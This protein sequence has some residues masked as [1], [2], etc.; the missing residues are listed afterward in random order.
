MKHFDR[1]LQLLRVQ[2]VRPYIKPGARVLDIGCADGALYRSVARLDH[3]VGI[4]PD[5]PTCSTSANVRF[6]RG[7][8]PTA[9][10]DPHEQFD[11]IA[12]LAVLEHVPRDAHTEFARACAQHMAPGGYLAITVPSPIVDPI[13]S[14]LKSVGLLDGMREDQHY[15]YDP[16]TTPSIFERHGLRLDRH[17]RFELGLNHLFVFQQGRG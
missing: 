13:I 15:G 2:R 12:A 7:T 4:D 17:A 8:F 5:A 6:I 14:A 11:V 9:A 3:Y 1:M 10:L 16:R